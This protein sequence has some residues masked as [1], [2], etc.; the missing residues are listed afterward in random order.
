[1]RRFLFEVL[2]I[3]P[4]CLFCAWLWFVPI[5]WDLAHGLREYSAA[6]W[7]VFFQSSRVELMLGG[8]IDHLGTLWIFS[9]VDEIL[10]GESGTILPGIYAPFGFDLGKNTGFGWADA[11]LSWP[12]IRW[13]GVPAFYNLHVFL[14][15]ALS[16]ITI[17]AL[18]RT[19]GAPRLAALGLSTL[20]LFHPFAFT[21][22]YQGRP[23]Q[24]HWFFHAL[25]LLSLL[26]IHHRIC[27]SK[28]GVF[29]QIKTHRNIDISENGSAFSL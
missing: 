24:M 22:V 9:M 11:T 29:S 23:T 14:T 21:E 10:R 15:L 19:A 6:L 20:A 27:P 4:F 26:K 12:L 7:E 2:L 16:Q 3:V 13:L 8:G 28:S 25:F 1:M 18:F 17:V 5:F